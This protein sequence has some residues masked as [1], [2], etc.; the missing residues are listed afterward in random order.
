MICF[1]VV[2][3]VLLKLFLVP[4]DVLSL[5]QDLLLIVVAVYEH[6]CAKQ[7]SWPRTVVCPFLAAI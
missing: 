3:I 6:V 4:S 5:K 7:F 1:H 2:F